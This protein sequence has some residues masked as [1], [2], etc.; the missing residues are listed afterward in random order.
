M[1]D[2][3]TCATQETQTG[4][5][6]KSPVLT[7]TRHRKYCMTI[8]NYDD[9]EYTHIINELQQGKFI[10]GKEIGASATKHLQ[11]YVEWKNARQ[12]NVMKQLFP[13]AHIEVAKGKR[14]ANYAYCSKDGDFA[15]N[16]EDP[17]KNA[18]KFREDVRKRISAKLEV[19]RWKRWQRDVLEELRTEPDERTINWYWEDVGG[20]GKT[21]LCKYICTKFEGVIICDGKKS[22]IFNQVNM[23]LENCQTP[24]IIIMDVPRTMEDHVSYGTLENL[25]NGLL[26]SGKYEGGQCLFECPHVFVFANFPPDETKMSADRWNVRQLENCDLA[27]SSELA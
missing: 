1:C 26:F 27:E 10:C 14:D 12:F 20:V 3:A 6:T 9:T 15:T 25:K 4:G 19:L 13:R 8:N 2:S 17:Q 5:N 11:I 16:M 23:T 18:K 22:D 7:S 21:T 24:K